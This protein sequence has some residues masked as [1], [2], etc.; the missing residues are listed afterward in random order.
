[1]FSSIAAQRASCLW[2][3][4]ACRRKPLRKPLRCEQ[5]RRFVRGQD[6]KCS[7]SRRIGFPLWS[8]SC[9]SA[10]SIEYVISLLARSLSFPYDYIA[11]P[12]LI[13]VESVLVERDGLTGTPARHTTATL[14]LFIT[15]TGIKGT[16]A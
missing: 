14:G 15:P 16:A 9:T 7:V 13:V 3:I 6:D 10:I 11:T 8:L 4:R 12:I 1:M 5:T 2:L